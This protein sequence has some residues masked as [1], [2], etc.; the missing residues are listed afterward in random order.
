MTQNKVICIDHR[1]FSRLT[2]CFVHL[3]REGT[4]FRSRDFNSSNI[5][6]MSSCLSTSVCS[7]SQIAYLCW[8]FDMEMTQKE[9][10]PG[11]TSR[12]G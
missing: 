3:V 12:F 11:D 8:H 1:R 5:D 10:L 2:A 9:T 4:H 6:S 7:P